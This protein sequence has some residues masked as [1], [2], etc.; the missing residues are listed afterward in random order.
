MLCVH[1]I[2]VVAQARTMALQQD[3][4]EQVMCIH[5]ACAGP[6]GVAPQQNLVFRP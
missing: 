1:A 2:R 5:Y 3:P 6:F 4:R